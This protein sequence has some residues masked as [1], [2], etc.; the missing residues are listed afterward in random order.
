MIPD[1]DP[2]IATV[3]QNM[4]IRKKSIRSRRG[5]SMF[6][7]ERKNSQKAVNIII[8]IVST[9]FCGPKEKLKLG[10]VA[11]KS[12]HWKITFKVQDHPAELILHD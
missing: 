3:P 1:R 8:N 6:I 7:N 12:T 11:F 4:K 5:E 10:A 2:E 9:C